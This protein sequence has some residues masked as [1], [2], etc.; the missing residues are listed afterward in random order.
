[1]TSANSKNG[2]KQQM[3]N[4]GNNKKCLEN[5]IKPACY[6]GVSITAVAQR[7]DQQSKHKEVLL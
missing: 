2:Q 3:I 5:N 7:G 1:V 6:S 4:G